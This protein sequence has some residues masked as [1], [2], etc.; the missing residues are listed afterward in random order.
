MYRSSYDDGR[1]DLY[2]AALRAAGLAGRDAWCMFDN[3]ASSAA[4]GDALGVV[5]RLASAGRG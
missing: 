1:L 5:D 3:T 4:I 2:A